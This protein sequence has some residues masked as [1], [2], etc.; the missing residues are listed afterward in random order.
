MCYKQHDIFGHIML[1][2]FNLVPL[3]CLFLFAPVCKWLFCCAFDCCAF[4][5]M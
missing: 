5:S 3:V 2:K 4:I 1:D